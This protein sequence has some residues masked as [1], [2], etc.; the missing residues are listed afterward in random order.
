MRDDASLAAGAQVLPETTIVITVSEGPE[1]RPAPALFNLTLDEATA[2][3]DALQLVLAR[4]DDVFS[5]DVEIGRV[6]LQE[7]PP[8]TLVDR[9]GVVSVQLSKGPDMVPIPD[10]NGLT[11]TEAEV[12]LTDAGYVINTLLGTTE[13]IFVSISVNGE[14]VQPGTL[15]IRG[16]GVDLVFL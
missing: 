4:G 11:F 9:G 8:E 10:L 3:T 12:A 16:T 14:E 13:G 15:F 6:V 7:P 5:I 1:P 2:S